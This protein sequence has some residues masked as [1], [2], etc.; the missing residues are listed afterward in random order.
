MEKHRIESIR[1]TAANILLER[2]FVEVLMK[3]RRARRF[4]G[5]PIR[6]QSE[7]ITDSAQL[8]WFMSL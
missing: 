7:H 1:L 5:V 6:R 2:V 4:R 8:T 3:W